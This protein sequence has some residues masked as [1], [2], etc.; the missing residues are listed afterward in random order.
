MV[1]IFSQD[2]GIEFGCEKIEMLIMYWEKKKRETTKA[3]ELLTQKSIRTFG[4][5]ESFKY[6]GVLKADSLKQKE[7]LKKVIKEYYRR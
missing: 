4:R 1:K 2:I 7:T 5:K 6:L 3:K